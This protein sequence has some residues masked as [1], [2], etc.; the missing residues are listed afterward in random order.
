MGLQMLLFVMPHLLKI[1]GSLLSVNIV[2]LIKVVWFYG[3]LQDFGLNVEEF[4]AMAY[5]DCP[6]QFLNV[7]VMCCQVS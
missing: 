3:L 5:E 4:S 2:S 7:A 6:S 1:Y